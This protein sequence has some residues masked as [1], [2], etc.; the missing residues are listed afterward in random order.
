MVSGLDISTRKARLPIHLKEDRLK[1][2]SLGG[3]FPQLNC[4]SYIRTS[5]CKTYFDNSGGGSLMNF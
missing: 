5:P 4:Y 2:R 1:V 3:V